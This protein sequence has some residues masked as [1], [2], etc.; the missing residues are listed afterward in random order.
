MI[1]PKIKCEFSGRHH[2]NYIGLTKEKVSKTVAYEKP[3]IQVLL[4]QTSN[5]QN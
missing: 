3:I 5:N 1:N 2:I 4:N